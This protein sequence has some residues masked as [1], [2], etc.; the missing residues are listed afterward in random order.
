MSAVL[1]KRFC[2]VGML[3]FLSLFAHAEYDSY[4]DSSFEIADLEVL[5]STYELYK[6]ENLKRAIS[7]KNNFIKSGKEQMEFAKSLDK[8]FY[9]AFCNDNPITRNKKVNQILRELYERSYGDIIN[10][11]GDSFSYND[12]IEITDAIYEAG[13]RTYKKGKS[14]ELLC[15]TIVHFNINGIE[16]YKNHIFRT[17]TLLSSVKVKIREAEFAANSQNALTASGYRLG[18]TPVD[19]SSTNRKGKQKLNKALKE[20]LLI[21]IFKL[22]AEHAIRD[23]FL[24]EN[25]IEIKDNKGRALSCVPVKIIDESKLVLITSKDMVVHVVPL[26]NI[27]KNSLSDIK[28][29]L[30]LE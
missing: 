6:P 16:S 3:I 28:S 13:Y 25:V 22:L 26:V 8:R 29:V 10:S 1:C 14:L 2:I 21:K 24:Y 15:E 27:S 12:T 7:D 23:V 19:T 11:L 5:I 9:I 20:E 17:N 30:G 4:S 18:A